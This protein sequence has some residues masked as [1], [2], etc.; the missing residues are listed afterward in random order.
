MFG[1]HQRERFDQPGYLKY[2]CKLRGIREK[3]QA[4]RAFRCRF[5]RRNQRTQARRI[6]IIRTG[7]IENDIAAAGIELALNGATQNRRLVHVD[8]AAQAQ[9]AGLSIC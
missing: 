3:L 2:A 9:H 6:K 5:E 8:I 1:R 4:R 7:R